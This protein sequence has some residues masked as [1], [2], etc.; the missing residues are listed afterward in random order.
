MNKTNLT[1]KT[2]TMSSLFRIIFLVPMM[3][4]QTVVSAADQKSAIN[5]KV[6]S[7]KLVLT[8]D[9]AYQWVAEHLDSLANSYLMKSGKILDPDNVRE[10]LKTIGYNGL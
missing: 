9:A 4:C 8:G 3:L 10:E 1:K 5:E 2:I 7:A 6:D